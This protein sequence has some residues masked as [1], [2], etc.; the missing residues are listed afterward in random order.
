MGKIY[1]GIVLIL[2]IA[3]G[4]MYQNIK[5]LNS[6]I[7]NKNHKIDEQQK[8]IAQQKA[9]IKLQEDE[10]KSLRAKFETTDK[11]L[12]ENKA[13]QLELH[14]NNQDLK[15]KIGRLKYE[16]EGLKNQLD[17]PL[18][19]L[20]ISM[21]RKPEVKNYY[22]DQNGI[23]HASNESSNGDSC[24]SYTTESLVNYAIDLEKSLDSCNADKKSIITWIEEVTKRDNVNI[25]DKTLIESQKQIE[26]SKKLLNV[27]HGTSGVE[28]DSHKKNIVT[29]FKKAKRHSKKR[30]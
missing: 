5:L 24:P 28:H 15:N 22:Y 23:C 27:P 25:I 17:T 7:E 21:L 11:V 19:N 4:G 20:I 26:I 13:K 18:D 8:E 16:N 12:S 14:K 6:E 9:T 29:H 3:L 10:N 1:A 2:I 30:G